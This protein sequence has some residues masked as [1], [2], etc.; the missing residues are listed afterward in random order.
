VKSKVNDPGYVLMPDGRRAHIRHAHAALNTLLQG[1]GAIICKAWIVEFNRRMTA[2]FGP[3]GWRGKWAALLWVH[4]EIQVAV[5]PEIADRAAEIAVEAIRS[6]TELFGW[7][8]PLD[9]EAKLG[10]N[11]AETH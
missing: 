9:G 5:R 1:A 3:Q 6:I 10:S 2:E 11:W 8:L 7:R 4:D